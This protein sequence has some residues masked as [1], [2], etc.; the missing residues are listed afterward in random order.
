M[1]GSGCAAP[2][3]IPQLPPRPSSTPFLSHPSSVVDRTHRSLRAA[4]DAVHRHRNQAEPLGRVRAPS[5]A[6]PLLPGST[7]PPTAEGLS[8]RHTAPRPLFGAPGTG[9]SQLW[10]RWPRRPGPRGGGLSLGRP[11]Q[12]PVTGPP[13]QPPSLSH[14]RARTC[15][16]AG[17]ARAPPRR[18]PAPPSAQTSRPPPAPPLR[19]A[20]CPD[21][22]VAPRRA[23]APR[24]PRPSARSAARPAGAAATR[25]PRSASTLPAAALL[26]SALSGRAARQWSAATVG[27]AA[28]RARRTQ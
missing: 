16:A 15:R 23:I 26:L 28:G 14:P 24:R 6:G 4:A 19:S 3:V 17:P 2:G 20:T 22:G 1:R 18:R 21:A 12:D 8:L 27:R 13:A 25:P 9:T 5:A 10:E 11:R 7:A